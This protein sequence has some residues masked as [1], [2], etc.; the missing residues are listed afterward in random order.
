MPGAGV[1][2]RR[3]REAY[4]YPLYEVFLPFCAEEGIEEPAWCPAGCSTA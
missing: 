1:A 4:R 3:V 2:I